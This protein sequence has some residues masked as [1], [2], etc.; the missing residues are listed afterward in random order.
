[1][2]PGYAM[3]KNPPPLL[4]NYKAEPSLP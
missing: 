1:M 2:Y 3:K 4:G